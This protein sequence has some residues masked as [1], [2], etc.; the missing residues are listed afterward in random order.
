MLIRQQ[1]PSKNWCTAITPRTGMTLS[2]CSNLAQK[3]N[4]P[5]HTTTWVS[6]MTHTLGSWPGLQLLQIPDPSICVMHQKKTDAW[7][8]HPIQ[9]MGCCCCKTT[10]S[11]VHALT[12][13]SC[14][15]KAW[16]WLFQHSTLS[17]LQASYIYI[18]RLVP[19]LTFTHSEPCT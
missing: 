4:T 16:T 11:Q 6:S 8:P 2:I 19:N 3:D 13:Q 12:W 17:L 7:R 10:Q 9:R 18:V 15:I 5:C 14:H 1:P